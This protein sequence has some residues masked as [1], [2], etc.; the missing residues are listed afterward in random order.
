MMRNVLYLAV[1][2]LWWYRGRTLTIVLCLSLTAWLPVTARLL[3]HQFRADL[4]LRAEQTP[5]I[6]GTKGSQIDL[7]LNS[8]YFDTVMPDLS[9]MDE[10]FYIR[11][12]KLA[13]ACG[14]VLFERYLKPRIGPTQHV[15]Y[16]VTWF[17]L[18]AALTWMVRKFPK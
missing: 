2:S 4:M 12:T 11:D 15:Q 16:A 13:D 17:T 6:V 5:L 9:T 7:A 10:V 3:L 18:T 14:P 1:R 8:L